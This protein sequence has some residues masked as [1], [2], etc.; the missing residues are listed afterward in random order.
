[1]ASANGHGRSWARI[2]SAVFFGINTL[3][4]IISFILVRAAATT[5]VSVVIWLVGLTAIVL[6]FGRDSGPYYSQQ[7]STA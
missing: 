3:D 6:L 7:T 1:M 4:L 2:V 5:I